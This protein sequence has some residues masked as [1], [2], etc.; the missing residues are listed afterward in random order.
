[1]LSGKSY[2]EGVFYLVVL[3][4]GPVMYNVP[5]I[6]ILSDFIFSYTEFELVHS[7]STVRW[8][9]MGIYWTLIWR[10]AHTY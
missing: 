2:G 3:R 9:A 6:N 7:N 5:F 10:R 4:G 1:M 8:D